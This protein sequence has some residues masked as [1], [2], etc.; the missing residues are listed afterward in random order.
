MDNDLALYT[1]GTGENFH[2]QDYLGV[3][4]I[5]NDTGTSYVF[6]VWAPNAEAVSLIGDF[7]DWQS[8]PLE[9][10]RN[11]AGVWELV[12][13]LPHEGDIYKYWVRRQGGQHVEKID[14]VAFLFEARPGTGAIVKTLPVKNGVIA[15]GWD[16]ESVL[17]LGSV[18][19]IFT[20]FMPIHGKRR[21]RK[22][23]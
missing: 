9:M 20:R 16:V 19:L 7:T 6:R 14:P 10:T 8:N 23:L 13:S 11:E 3:H 21:K 15:Y 17:A 18:Q 4:R 5:N 1:F 22:A 12:T 2:V